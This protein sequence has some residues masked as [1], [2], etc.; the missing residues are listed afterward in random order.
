M[1]SSP[2]WLVTNAIFQKYVLN[3]S[4]KIDSQKPKKQIQL[5]YLISI[6][7]F[8]TGEVRTVAWRW[9]LS[10][11]MLFHIQRA[12]QEKESDAVK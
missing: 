12:I 11:D 3:L 9:T 6:P 4:L 5:Q 7:S 1:V 2:N 8:F 10:I